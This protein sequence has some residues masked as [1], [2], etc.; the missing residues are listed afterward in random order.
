MFQWARNLLGGKAPSGPIRARYDNSLTTPESR[1]EWWPADYLS[2]KSANS[3]QVRRTL[4]I[5]SRYEVSN[6]PYL[7]GI[8]NTNADD[9]IGTG[10]TLQLR[11][12]DEAY[13]REVQAAWNEW[14]EEVG[15]TEKLR[16]Q[17]L[18]KTVDGEGFLVLKNVPDLEQPVKLYP[19]DIEADQVTSVAP[20][21]LQELW[22]DGITL[23]PV[24]QRPLEYQVLKSH[25]GDFFFPG[26]NPL[27]LERVSARNVLHWFPKFRPGQV[28]GVPVF[29][30]SLDMFVELRDF[31]KATLQTVR[32][33][34]KLTAVVETEMPAA[35]GDEDSNRPYEPFESFAINNG[36]FT[37]LPSGAK[38]NAFKSDSPNSTYEMFTRQ[39]LGEA[40][41]PLNFPL[42]KALGTSE[43]SNF[44]SAKLDYTDYR[45]GLDVERSD[46]E[47]VN[48]N[49]LFR[50]WYPEAVLSGAIRAWDG[51]K[52]PPKEWHWPGYTSLDPLN[53][54][55]ADSL[56]LSSG[57]DTLQAFWARKGYDWKRVLAQLAAERD[58]MERF[59]LT[60]G[61]PV[62]RSETET[63]DS[64]SEGEPGIAKAILRRFIQAIKDDN[65]MEH[66]D[67]GRFG[68]GGSSHSEEAAKHHETANHH[69]S[70]AKKA[71][72]D[73]D[74]EGAAAHR[75]A[76]HASR[77]VARTHEELHRVKEEHQAAVEKSK[78]DHERRKA[79]ADKKVSEAESRV[80]EAK[81]K[82]R[83][84][85][86]RVDEAK[87]GGDP[88]ERLADL[89]KKLADS[90]KRSREAVA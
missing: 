43:K 45:A 38:M 70:E 12:S 15:L 90:K 39:C 24:T 77:Q 57:Q 86:D 2:A 42:L 78:R 14:A 40:C 9:L 67:D 51:M 81:R 63:T 7:F 6:N 79:D 69:A 10:P 17:K 47:A 16:T 53:D 60:F 18:A 84:A 29:T 37:T 58:E 52:L 28:R 72:S 46:C 3:Y 56:R 30:P 13:N 71:A 36:M 85:N 73:G 4:R 66:D 64:D 23:H 44:S 89:K 26:L 80:E 54:A 82:E 88:R 11:T 59:N 8:C 32:T 22:I 20:K 34:A 62:K 76:E 35:G 74:H 83:A 87:K 41:R 19:C 5:R 33:H 50:E 31:R 61:E 49:K 75:E 68:T 48:L 65:G 21:N 55:N 27:A 25:P 1:R